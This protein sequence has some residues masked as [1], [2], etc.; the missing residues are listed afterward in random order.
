MPDKAFRDL[1]GSF[2]EQH[3]T[4]HGKEPLHHGAH[5]SE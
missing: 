2:A 5:T 1:Y 4:G 3:S